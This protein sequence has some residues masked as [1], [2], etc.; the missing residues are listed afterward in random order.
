MKLKH[1]NTA[2]LSPKGNTPAPGKVGKGGK[3]IN[4]HPIPSTRVMRA[5]NLKVFYE[6]RDDGIIEHYLVKTRKGNYEVKKYKARWDWLFYPKEITYETITFILKHKYNGRVY[7]I[8]TPIP[9]NIPNLKKFE[10]I[11]SRYP[12]TKRDINKIYQIVLAVAPVKEF[13]LPDF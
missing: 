6:F 11:L 5:L 10:I 1:Q 4:S 12:L 3:V 13:Y 7:E 9:D 8:T 2:G